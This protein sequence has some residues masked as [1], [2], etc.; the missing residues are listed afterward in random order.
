MDRTPR[1]EDPRLEA[2]LDER[3][4][5]LIEISLA[6]DAE[7]PDADAI[8]ALHRRLAMLEQQIARR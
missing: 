6:A 8:D 5:L 7:A 4:H 1:A 2:L 3:D